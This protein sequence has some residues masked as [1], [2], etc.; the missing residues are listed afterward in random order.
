LKKEHLD[1]KQV[2]NDD[3]E[4]YQK[5][6]DDIGKEYSKLKRQRKMLRLNKLQ[7]DGKKN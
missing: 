6:I 7:R 3:D 5:H 2:N 1:E 4:Q